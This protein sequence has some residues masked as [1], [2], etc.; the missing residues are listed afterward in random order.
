MI[1]MMMMMM[2]MLAVVMEDVRS[3]FTEL[4]MRLRPSTYLPTYLPTYLRIH[5]DW[6]WLGF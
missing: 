6:W 3:L 2:M 5:T 1:R 4:L